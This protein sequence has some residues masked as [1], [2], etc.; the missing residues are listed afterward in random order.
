VRCG[1]SAVERVSRRLSPEA[2]V[3]LLDRIEQAP[4]PVGVTGTADILHDLDVAALD[5]VVVCPAGG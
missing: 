4:A 1:V 3:A 5:Q 2:I